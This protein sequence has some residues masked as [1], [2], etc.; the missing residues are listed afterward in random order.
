MV[1]HFLGL[2]E[3]TV[4][5]AAGVVPIDTDDLPAETFLGVLGVTGLTA[6]LGIT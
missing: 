6:W 4:I 5:D 3:A 2:R 1:E